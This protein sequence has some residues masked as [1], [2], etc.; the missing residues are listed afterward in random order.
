MSDYSQLEKLEQEAAALKAKLELV[1]LRKAAAAN[2]ALH[3]KLAAFEAAQREVKSLAGKLD[4]REPL[5]DKADARISRFTDH[6]CKLRASIEHA[7]EMI[8]SHTARINVYKAARDMSEEEWAEY[9]GSQI[10]EAQA[11]VDAAKDD[12]EDAASEA[13][14]DVSALTS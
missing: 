13:G 2:P 6:I 14:V 1:Q 5:I 11:R 9:M 8:E 4:N 3:N 12:F 10:A 7:E